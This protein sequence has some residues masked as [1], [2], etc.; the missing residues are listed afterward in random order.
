MMDQFENDL[1]WWLFTKCSFRVWG[2][3]SPICDYSFPCVPFHSV[4]IENSSNV[5]EFAITLFEPLQFVHIIIQGDLEPY[6]RRL[7]CLLATGNEL[8]TI[9]GV[10]RQHHALSPHVSKRSWLESH[11]TS[12]TLLSWS[13]SIQIQIRR[14]CQQSKIVQGAHNSETAQIYSAR[15]THLN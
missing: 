5:W 2:T 9:N 11:F 14:L 15:H 8:W 12:R 3:C 4:A 10:Q 7:Y 1:V 6:I 13:I